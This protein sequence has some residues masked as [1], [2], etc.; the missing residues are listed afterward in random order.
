[1]TLPQHLEPY[2]SQDNA[3]LNRAFREAVFPGSSDT[4]GA[5]QQSPADFLLGCI[6]SSTCTSYYSYITSI[7]TLNNNSSRQ[8]AMDISY[9]GDI[10]DDLGH[11]LTND[12]SS[13]AV[14]LKVTMDKWKEECGGHSNKVI[15]MVRQARGMSE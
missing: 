12:L 7:S 10:L 4:S 2:M 13:T 15:A 3:P 6:S 8:L 9:L 14:L 1:M 11:P 5:A